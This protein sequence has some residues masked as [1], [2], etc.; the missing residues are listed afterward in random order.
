MVEPKPGRDVMAGK[1]SRDSNPTVDYFG[2]A[3]LGLGDGGQEEEGGQTDDF[4][5]MFKAS[6]IGSPAESDGGKGFNFNSFPFGGGND[7]EGEEEDN[8]G[9]NFFGF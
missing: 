5:S 8:T 4:M 2:F 1:E 6:G 7:E 3:G 9:F